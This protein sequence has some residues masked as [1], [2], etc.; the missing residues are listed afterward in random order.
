[1]AGGSI[2]LGYNTSS[3]IKLIPMFQRHQ[4]SYKYR[5]R[6]STESG[7]YYRKPIV[8]L[9]V[10]MHIRVNLEVYQYLL[11][12]SPLTIHVSEEILDCRKRI[13]FVTKKV[14]F[15]CLNPLNLLASLYI[16]YK[17]IS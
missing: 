10:F 2:F 13:G 1:M 4:F 6:L 16:K 12:R 15:K 3:L 8:N 5:K 17:A 9:C 7:L 11:L 14:S